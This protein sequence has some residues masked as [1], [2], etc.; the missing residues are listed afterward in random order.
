[1]S[2]MRFLRLLILPLAALAL[3]A[4][5]PKSDPVFGAKVRAYLLEH[6]EVLQEVVDKLQ[7]KQAAEK[8]AQ[9]SQALRKN[10]AALERDKR[11]FVA[12]PHGKVTVVEFFDYNCGYCKVIAPEVMTLVRENPDVRFVF[13]DMT[14]FGPTS[15]YAA[16]AASTLK[17]DG[18]RYLSAHQ[19]MM[20][21][22]PLDPEGVER[23]LTTYGGDPAAARQAQQSNAQKEYLADVHK[24]AA[25]LGIEGTPAFVVGDVLIPGADPTAL[26]QAIAAARKG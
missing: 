18:K 4:C 20:A 16:A 5:E 23:I 13:K 22:K 7:E 26:K 21:A 11:D 14:I 24:L 3:S 8:L 10:R 17:R 19:A 6:P 15:E 25:E 9:A 1:M 12:N 2:S